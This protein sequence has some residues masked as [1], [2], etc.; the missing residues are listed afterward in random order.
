MNAG[1]HRT[2]LR[3][4]VEVV[5]NLFRTRLESSSAL[6]AAA[7]TEPAKETEGTEG[8]KVRGFR[9]YGFRV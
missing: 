5:L 4:D 2:F 1:T 9:L 7:S 8:G 3:P 6:E